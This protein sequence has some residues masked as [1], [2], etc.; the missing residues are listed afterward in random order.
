M[1]IL[2]QQF[3]LIVSYTLCFVLK[4][5][6]SFHPFILTIGPFYSSPCTS[7]V[8]FLLVPLSIRSERSEK[9]RYSPLRLLICQYNWNTLNP[10]LINSASIEWT[11]VSSCTGWVYPCISSIYNL[12]AASA[13]KRLPEVYLMH[14]PIILLSIIEACLR[15]LGARC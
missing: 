10:P 15:K 4:R 8:T 2:R 5:L 13:R 1:H 14:H 3:S 11:L 9:S 12:L 6:G 7:L